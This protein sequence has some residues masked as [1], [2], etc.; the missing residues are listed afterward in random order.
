MTAMIVESNFYNVALGT[1]KYR[2]TPVETNFDMTKE[3]L[4][5]FFRED[6][7]KRIL[8]DFNNKRQ[9]DF[10]KPAGIFAKAGAQQ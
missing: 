2:Y 5:E 9:T 6:I 1:D 3:E 4:E 10:T 7:Y 8:P